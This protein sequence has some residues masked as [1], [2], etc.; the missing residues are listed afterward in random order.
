MTQNKEFLILGWRNLAEFLTKEGFPISK[1][2]LAK[3]STMGKGPPSHGSW[4]KRNTFLPSEV[5][6]WAHAREQNRDRV[7]PSPRS[8]VNGC[9]VPVQTAPVVTEEDVPPF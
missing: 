9:L 5:L 8:S 7:R 2:T 3:Y 6:A 1:L 4:S